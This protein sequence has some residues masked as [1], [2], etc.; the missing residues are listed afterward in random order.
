[1]RAQ[2][3]RGHDKAKSFCST[4]PHIT[5]GEIEGHREARFRTSLAEESDAELTL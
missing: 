1:M 4:E 3:Q 5:L 2:S